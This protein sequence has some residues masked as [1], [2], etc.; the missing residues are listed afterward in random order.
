MRSKNEK[1]EKEKKYEQNEKSIG[2]VNGGL[3]D[4]GDTGRL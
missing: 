4:H 1:N 2:R 3:H